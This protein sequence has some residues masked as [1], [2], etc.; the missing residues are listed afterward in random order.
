MTATGS[1]PLGGVGGTR[2]CPHPVTRIYSWIAAD[3]TLVV[4]CLECK[5]VL[6]GGI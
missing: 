5:T 1:A 3:K 6:R 2:Q 4:C